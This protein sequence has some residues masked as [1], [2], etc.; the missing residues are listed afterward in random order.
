MP[1]VISA[2]PLVELTENALLE[3][4]MADFGRS[5][6]KADQ[7]PMETASNEDLSSRLAFSDIADRGVNE[8][9][10]DNSVQELKDRILQLCGG[11][12]TSSEVRQSLETQKAREAA[13]KNIGLLEQ[14]VHYLKAKNELDDVTGLERH[15]EALK[16]VKKLTQLKAE[17]A[18]NEDFEQ[19]IVYKRHIADLEKTLLS[20]K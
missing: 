5:A 16:Q 15:I 11:S 10:S 3:G 9:S 8:R 1:D 2:K 19:A 7:A 4:F 14:V 6:Q 18:E 13:L 12:E 20:E 17:A